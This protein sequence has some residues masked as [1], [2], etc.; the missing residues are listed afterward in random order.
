MTVRDAAALLTVL[1]ADGIDYAQHAVPGRLA[2]KR[3][4]VPRETYWGYCSHGDAAAERALRRCSAAE[5]ATIV[6]HTDLPDLGDEVCED[7]LR[8]AARGVRRRGWRTT[9]RPAPATDRGP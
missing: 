5:G 7:E 4:G 2:G 3:I 1:A 8:G 9:S 6:D